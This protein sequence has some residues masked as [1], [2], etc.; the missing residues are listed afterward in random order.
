MTIGLRTPADRREVGV[1]L[2][3]LIENEMRALAQAVRDRSRHHLFPESVRGEMRDQFRHLHSLRRRARWEAD[4]A[5]M[6][7]MR[8]DLGRRLPT[9]SLPPDRHEEAWAPTVSESEL[10][11][12]WG[13]R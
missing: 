8:A 13:D 9:T 11:A 6:T 5:P 3:A 10:R 1:A 7:F 12:A 4:W 2:L